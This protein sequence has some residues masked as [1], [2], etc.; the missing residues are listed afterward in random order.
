M[1]ID[2]NPARNCFHQLT[3]LKPAKRTLERQV[4][5]GVWLGDDGT[6]VEDSIES[7]PL[8]SSSQLP[9]LKPR[10]RSGFQRVPSLVVSSAEAAARRKIQQCVDE[11][12]EDVDLSYV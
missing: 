3:Q 8:P 12:D 2:D 1:T 4:D 11:G 7:P 6:D 9:E 5:S 10:Q